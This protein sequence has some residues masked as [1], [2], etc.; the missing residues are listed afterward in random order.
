MWPARCFRGKISELTVEIQRLHRSVSL[1]S[2]DQS[3]YVSYEKRSV[4]EGSRGGGGVKHFSR[5]CARHR[6]KLSQPT[7]FVRV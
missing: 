5:S 6:H 3:S 1:A 7:N 2:D 4:G